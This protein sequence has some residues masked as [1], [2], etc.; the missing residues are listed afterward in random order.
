MADRLTFILEP[1]HASHCNK[2]TPTFHFI[3]IIKGHGT[4]FDHIFTFVN[5]IISHKDKTSSFFFHVRSISC[6]LPEVALIG[7]VLLTE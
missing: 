6:V 2:A 4:D 5:N 1:P 3:I 7:G